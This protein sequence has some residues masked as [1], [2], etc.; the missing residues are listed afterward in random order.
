MLKKRIIPKILLKEGRAVKGV[1]FEDLRDVGNPV[2][3]ARIYDAQGAD[4][5]IFLDIT[6]SQEKRDILYDVISRTAE[7][8]FMPFT[9]GGGVKTLDDIRLLLKA[10]ADKISINTAAVERPE[11]LP[12]AADRFGSQCLIGAVDFKISDN[13]QYRIFT[14]GGQ[15]ETDI[16]PLIWSLKLQEMGV[17]ELLLTSIDRDGT[18]EGFDLSLTRWIADAVD[19]P[20]IAAGG[21]GTLAHLAQGFT[22][23]HASAVAVGSLF[24]F[25]DQS[26][27]KARYYL[28]GEGIDVRV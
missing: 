16:D 21:A 8:C 4:E 3:N 7:E 15:V 1:R 9:V 11:F 27:I 2:T 13:G 23:G 12:E 22:E 24:H 17:G 19:V 20:T 25:T 6:A 26:P 28:K 5:L 14:H 10:G 18:S